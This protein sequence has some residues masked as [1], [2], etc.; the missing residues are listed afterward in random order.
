MADLGRIQQL[1][2]TNNDYRSRFLRDQV[3]APAEQG[4]TLPWEM[5]MK[6]RQMVAGAQTPQAMVP[7]AAVGQIASV[8]NT[9]KTGV[10]A[11]TR[12]LV[13]FTVDEFPM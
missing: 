9:R 8:W 1:L 4:L 5:H 7:G 10:F 6:L 11:E 13:R 12:K 3:A 2:N